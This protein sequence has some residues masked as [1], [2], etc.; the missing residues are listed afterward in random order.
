M[1][2]VPG[3]AQDEGLGEG[4][5]LTNFL[6]FEAFTKAWSRGNGGQRWGVGVRGGGGARD[7]HKGGDGMGGR[8]TQARASSPRSAPGP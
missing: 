6:R 7:G 5:G 2:E 3:C 8:R 1:K 4:R